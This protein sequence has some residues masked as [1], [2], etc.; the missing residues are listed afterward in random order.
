MN[1]FQANTDVLVG[2]KV[3]LTAVDP[4]KPEVGRLDFFID[5]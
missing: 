5:W 1:S 4:E 3:Q 2:V